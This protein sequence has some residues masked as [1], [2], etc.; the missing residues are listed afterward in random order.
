VASDDIKINVTANTA[1]FVK[2]LEKAE[3]AARDAGEAVDKIDDETVTL[4]VDTSE[5]DK[6]DTSLDEVGTSAD[7]S[8]NVMANFAGNSAQD[9]GELAGVTGSTGVALGQI[10]EYAT[11]GGISL[12]GL[13][14]TAGP[15]LAVGFAVEQISSEMARVK[16][17]DAW[18]TKRIDD[19]AT[20]IKNGATELEAL[21]AKIREMEAV[22]VRL[23][24]VDVVEDITDKVVDLGLNA[25]TF[26]QIAAGGEDAIRAWGD[27]L[28]GAGANAQD[29]T[30]VMLAMGQEY[31]RLQQATESAK[32][33]QKFLSTEMGNTGNIDA[34]SDAVRVLTA[35][36]QALQRAMAA[37]ANTPAPAPTV[38]GPVGTRT[39]TSSR[40][41]GTTTVNNFFPSAPTPG[42]VRRAEQ[43]YQR[44]NG[45]G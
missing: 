19:Y 5:I 36:Y 24:L 25:T 27:G 40:A 34:N 9:I 37:A 42:Q 18:D 43:E 30:L 7:R 41:T 29:V 1:P 13:A 12:K 3:Q 28:T 2:S 33:S 44:V 26:S 39:P 8:K 16:A 20:A 6:L 4:H 35:N 10:A 45:P 17:N 31:D 32:V 14:S 21:E 38:A 15:M 23:P 11:E 22:E